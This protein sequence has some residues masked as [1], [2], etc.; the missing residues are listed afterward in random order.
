MDVQV[1]PEWGGLGRAAVS[2]RFGE[3]DNEGIRS[4]FD[5]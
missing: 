1:L 3:R 2:E 4:V 5:D